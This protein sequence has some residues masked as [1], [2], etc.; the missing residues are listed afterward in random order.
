MIKSNMPSNFSRLDAVQGSREA[1]TEMY[2][3][4]LRGSTGTADDAMR[5]ECAG[6]LALPGNVADGG[7]V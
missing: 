5:Q 2:E 6:Y 4:V 7:G 3:T 1:R